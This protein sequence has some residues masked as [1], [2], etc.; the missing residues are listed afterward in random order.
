MKANYIAQ[1]LISKN[2]HGQNDL[3]ISISQINENYSKWINNITNGYK[4]EVTIY[5]EL[6]MLKIAYIT[7]MGMIET[8]IAEDTEFNKTK[9]KE[10]AMESSNQAKRIFLKE[11]QEK[12]KNSRRLNE[13]QELRILPRTDIEVVRSQYIRELK[14][15]IIDLDKDIQNKQYNINRAQKSE[16]ILLAKKEAFYN[17]SDP[18]YKMK[19]DD[20]LMFNFNP[21]QEH[22]YVP[23]NMAE[24]TYFPAKPQKHTDQVTGRPYYALN[25]IRFGNIS[26]GDNQEIIATHIGNIGIGHMRRE[27]GKFNYQNSELIKVYRILKRYK[28]PKMIEMR[29]KATQ[30]DSAVS[31]WD[32]EQDGEVFRV[33]GNL[34]ESILLNPNVDRTFV[35]YTQEVL[36]S[37]TNLEEAIEHNGGYIGEVCLEKDSGEYLVRHDHDSLCAAKE[38]Q[39]VT[40]STPVDDKIIIYKIDQGILETYSKDLLSGKYL[41]STTYMPPSKSKMKKKY[42]DLGEK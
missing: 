10:N 19:L 39:K 34:L 22:R 35:Q 6:A 42:I 15:W 28:D 8:D 9:L 14:S 5:E 37:T 4:D 3:L 2:H 7:I 24:V 23:A 32:D 1:L 21:N 29:K 36:L 25:G 13:Y 18:E 27:N 26:L 20:I 38:F 40:K 11:K 41:R 33:S 31:I 12:E 17:L 30:R 16:A